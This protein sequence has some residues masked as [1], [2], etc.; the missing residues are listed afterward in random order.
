MLRPDVT[1]STTPFL[2]LSGADAGETSAS[3]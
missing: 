1:T 2:R 3:R